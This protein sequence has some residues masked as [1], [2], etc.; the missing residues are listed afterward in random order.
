MSVPSPESTAFQPAVYTQAA[1]SLSKVELKGRIPNHHAN[2]REGLSE[3]LSREVSDFNIR[4]LV[5]EPGAFRTRFLRSCIAPKK[6]TTSDYVDTTVG[7]TL[8]YFDGLNGT[9]RGDPAKGA[10]R[11]FDVVTK[12]GIA[13]GL[14]EEYLRLPIGADCLERVDI[15][16]ENMKQNIEALRAIALGTDL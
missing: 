5:V 16:L 6:E 15:K 13:S 2:I 3:S 7:K 9:Q 8:K 11:I 4:V 14:K 10:S 1:N 12:S